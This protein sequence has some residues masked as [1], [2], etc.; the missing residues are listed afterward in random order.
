M[1]RTRAKPQIVAGE[2]ATRLQVV[3]DHLLKDIFLHSTSKRRP[4]PQGNAHVMDLETAHR[5]SV[6]ILYTPALSSRR[7]TPTSMPTGVCRRSGAVFEIL[8]TRPDI[9][10]WVAVPKPCVAGSNPAGGTTQDLRSGRICG[11]VAFGFEEDW[12]CSGP[13]WEHIVLPHRV[14]QAGRH[15]VE[16]VGEQV[17][18]SQV[19]ASGC[20]KDQV[21]LHPTWVNTRSCRAAR[22]QSI[23][24]QREAWCSRGTGV[25]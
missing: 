1:T 10:R 3:L 23:P 17:P 9:P 13:H 4:P 7:K 24:G 8:T 6:H 11:P 12:I 16:P 25:G 20:W 5:D 19:A 22:I 21:R 14:I 15:V 18:D 2:V